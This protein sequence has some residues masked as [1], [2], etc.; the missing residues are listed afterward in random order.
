MQCDLPSF[1]DFSIVW[2]ISFRK[3]KNR[4][5]ETKQNTIIVQAR[6]SSGQNLDCNGIGEMALRYIL[7]MAPSQLA[8]VL[9]IK[10]KEREASRLFSKFL[11]DQLGV[12]W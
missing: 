11:L 5:K 10:L 8:N 7:K 2:R 1:D 9:A 3:G 12:W 4:C 6:D